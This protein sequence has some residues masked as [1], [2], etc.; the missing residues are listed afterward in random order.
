[1]TFQMFQYILDTQLGAVT[2]CP[3]A[4]E[5][6]TIGHAVFLDKHGCGATAGDK[7]H[8]LGVKLGDRRVETATII[9]VEE[10]GAVGA[11]EGTAHRIDAVNNVLFD[12]STFGILFR[13][14]STDNDKALGALLLGEDIDGLGTEFGSDAENGAVDLGKVFHLGV[15]LDALHLGLLGVDSVDG[16]LEIAFEQI[17]EGFTAGLV[18][19]AGS[20]A[21]DDATGI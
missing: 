6:K 13:E 11:D 15:A 16:T 7:V 5:F 21:N 17:L 4:V 14:T 2:H 18:Y 10:S 20:T 9:G 1:M 19:I 12:G 8:T 3:N